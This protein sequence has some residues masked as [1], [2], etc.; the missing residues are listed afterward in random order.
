[1]TIGMAESAA[2]AEFA[3]FVEGNR[4]RLKRDAD[5]KAKYEA[6]LEQV[7]AWTPPTPEHVGVKKFMI[8]QLKISI[9]FDCGIG[10]DRNTVMQ[11]DGAAWLAKKIAACEACVARHEL[12]HAKE[13]ERTESC[14]KWLSDL[15]ESLKAAP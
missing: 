8:D 10:R 14:N 3:S 7:E 12:E 13:L 1:M 11:L 15:R 9:S 2:A 5:L 4:R 6:M